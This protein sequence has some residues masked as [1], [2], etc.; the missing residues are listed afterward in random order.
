MWAML[1]APITAGNDSRSMSAATKAILTNADV[2]AV[3]R[4]PLRK[5]ATLI[6]TSGSNLQ[7]WS[8]PLSGTLARSLI[9]TGPGRPHPCRCDPAEGRPPDQREQERGRTTQR[10]SAVTVP[11]VRPG[12]VA[13]TVIWPAAPV[14]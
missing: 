4:D 6:A 8:R 9:S 1:A 14:D 7:V 5:Q 2:A 10:A 11:T 13:V 12:E 3:D